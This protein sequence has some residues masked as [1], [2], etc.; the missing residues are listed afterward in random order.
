MRKEEKNEFRANRGNSVKSLLEEDGDKNEES[1]D[2]GNGPGGSLGESFLFGATC[3]GS[4]GKA[5]KQLRA[6]EQSGP[7]PKA[8]CGHGSQKNKIPWS[9][10]TYVKQ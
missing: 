5:G 10:I 8:S 1:T 2:E 4:S 7:T 9:S 6:E 3:R